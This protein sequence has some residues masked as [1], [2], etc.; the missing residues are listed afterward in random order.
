MS[1]GVTRSIL[2]VPLMGGYMARLEV[3]RWETVGVGHKMKQKTM[4]MFL[5]LTT[6]LKMGTTIPTNKYGLLLGS[7]SMHGRTNSLGS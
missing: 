5:M 3:N 2:G 6:Q 7:K 1:V 4:G